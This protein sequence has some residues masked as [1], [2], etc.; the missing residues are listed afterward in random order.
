M[1]ENI[2]VIIIHLDGKE[3]IIN[4]DPTITI[5]K[6]KIKFVQILNKAFDI[7]Y[8]KPP[9]VMIDCIRFV[10]AGLHL[11][12]SRKISD[13]NIVNGSNIHYYTQYISQ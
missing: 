9:P 11:N 6:L 12:D 7:T 1:T 13:Y 10:Y 5:F 8:T 2:D 3:T 4:V